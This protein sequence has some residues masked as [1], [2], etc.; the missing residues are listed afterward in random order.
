MSTFEYKS[1]SLLIKERV[2]NLKYG[3]LYP[4]INDEALERLLSSCEFWTND[5]P[6][7]NFGPNWIYL[8]FIPAKN[9]QATLYIGVR[10]YSTHIDIFKFSTISE[11]GSL[12]QRNQPNKK[13][14][15][16]DIGTDHKQLF[17]VLNDLITQCI[18]DVNS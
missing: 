2:N 17:D 10:Y 4:A 3:D 5:Q 7:D 8:K 18:K 11:L 12:T 9:K 13:L 1:I 14:Y 15:P 6:E 16:Q